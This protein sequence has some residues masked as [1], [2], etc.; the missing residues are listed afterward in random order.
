M[1]QEVVMILEFAPAGHVG[2]G[3]CPPERLRPQDRAQVYPPRPGGAGLSSSQTPSDRHRSLYRLL[4]RPRERLS[5]PDRLSTVLRDQGARLC[6]DDHA[7]LLTEPALSPVR[8]ALQRGNSASTGGD[9]SRIWPLPPRRCACRATL[10]VLVRTI[11]AA[12]LF[13]PSC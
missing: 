5:G 12:A 3:P 7:S 10:G 8:I 4:A 11:L 9:I 2:L 6:F 1:I 13:L